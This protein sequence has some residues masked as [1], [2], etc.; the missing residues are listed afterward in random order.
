MK[1]RSRRVLLATA[2]AA[3]GLAA[4]FAPPRAADSASS[5]ATEAVALD[6]PV[7]RAAA[8]APVPQTPPESDVRE[9]TDDDN[10]DTLRAFIPDA[11]PAPPP[12]PAAPPSPV[13]AVVAEAPKLPPPPSFRV[14]GRYRDG[15]QTRLFVVIDGHNLVV[16]KG[17]KIGGDY[18][19]DAI[20]DANLTV[21]YLPMDVAQ[22]IA[23]SGLN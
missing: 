4:V 8:S 15:D 9:R 6:L 20:S 16:G 10:V 12:P 23:L 11:P 22:D 14:V 2:L 3:T 18:L 5:V 7:L 1:A 21:H 19:V 17:E 13:Q